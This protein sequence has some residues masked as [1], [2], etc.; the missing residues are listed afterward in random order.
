MAAAKDLRGTWTKAILSFVFSILW[1]LVLRWALFEPYV[2]PSG[3]MIPSL[4]IHDHILVN[5]FSYGLRLPFSAN[6]LIRFQSPKRGDVLV[7]RSLEDDAVFVVKRV[8]GL[9]GDIVHVDERGLLTINGAKVPVRFLEA[10]EIKR[11]FADQPASL[12]DDLLSTYQVAE[13]SLDGRTHMVIYEKSR[14][15]SEVREFYIPED[16]LFFLGDNRDNSSDSRVWGSLPFQRVLGRASSIWL[17]C[18]ESLPDSNQLCDPGTIRWGRMF[19][20]VR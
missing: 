15:P 7:F 4:L 19:E 6:W 5:K 10:E 17:S 11:S 9:P 13:E 2:I 8:I 18:E 3:S 20:G 14:L 12:Q 1:I 16:S